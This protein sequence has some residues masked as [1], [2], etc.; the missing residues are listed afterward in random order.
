[1][2]GNLRKRLTTI[3]D[4]TIYEAVLS[5]IFLQQIAPYLCVSYI[6]Y[7]VPPSSNTEGIIDNLN[8]PTTLR[9]YYLKD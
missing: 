2:K 6:Y 4:D 8:S 9:L 7:R 3:W 1:M 5:K